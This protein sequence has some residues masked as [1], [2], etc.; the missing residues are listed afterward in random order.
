MKSYK[1][2]IVIA[3]IAAVSTGIFTAIL[4]KKNSWSELHTTQYDPL[5]YFTLGLIM[6]VYIL[7]FAFHPEKDREITKIKWLKINVILKW[8]F[9]I[10]AGLFLM[11]MTFGVN[12]EAALVQDLHI[13]FTGLAI[14]AGILTMVTYPETKKG[15]LVANTGA[16]LAV[17]GFSLGFNFRLYSTSWSEV[18]VALIFATFILITYKTQNK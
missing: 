5:L 13:V 9:L 7:A 18:V 3:L 1:S 15:H 11:V 2:L 4:D 12:H 10:T 14:M 17:F 16:G 8:A 6:A